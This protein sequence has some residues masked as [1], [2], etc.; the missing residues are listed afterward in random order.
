M[1]LIAILAAAL[2]NIIPS[3]VEMQVKDGC[4]KL[5]PETSFCVSDSQ[6]LGVAEFMSSKLSVSTGFRLPV[7]ECGKGDI[8]LVLDPESGL[9]REGYTLEVTKDRVVATAPD[10]A[11][12]FYAMQSFLQLLP[13]CADSRVKVDLKTWTAPCVSIRDYPRFGWRGFHV[14]P[15]RHFMTVEETKRQIDM[16]SEY[17]VNVMHWHLTDD[18]GWRIEIKKYPR[19]TEVG[20]WRTEF[21]GSVH[22]G[23]YTQEEIR[24]VVAYA[25][26]RFVT[27]VPEIEMPGHSFAAI[28]AYPWLSCLNVPVWD[29][30]V[31]GSP[32]IVLCPGSERVFRFLDDVAAEV[33]A[34]FPGEYF[35][36]G[37][38]ECQKTKWKECDACQARIR[39]EG[40][41]SDEEGT[42]E[43][44]LQSYAVKRMEGI[45]AKYGKKLIG[46]DEILEGGLSPNA[47]VMSWRG[48]K[49][50]IK[51][52]LAGHCVVMTPSHD[53]LYLDHF[54][55]DPKVEPVS[56]G[57]Y[58]TLEKIYGYNPVPEVLVQNGKAEYIMGVQANTWSE[59]LYSI[60]QREYMMY[61]RIFALAEIGWTPLENKDFKDFCRR[62][63]DAC[64]RADYHGINYH[65][66][67]PEQ[68]GGSYDNV[69]FT[70]KA[71]LEFK[72]TRPMRM[73]YTLDGS[74][75]TASSKQYRK[76]LEFTSD[77]TLRIA[78]V[79]TY[80][81]LS[82]VRTITIRKTL[83][84][85]AVT[86]S[87][88]G[89]RARRADGRFITPQD[90]K[91]AVWYEVK[92]GTLRDLSNLEKL[93]KNMPPS[94]R[95]YASKAE[96]YFSVPETGVYVFS[97]DC[98]QV[99]IDG[100]LVIDN[101]G[102]VKRFS[103]HDGG[104]ALEKG[105]HSVEVVFISNVIGGWTS[106]RNKSEVYIRP[107]SSEKS[108]LIS[109]VK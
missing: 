13:P 66:P 31:W 10:A 60:A 55:G 32:D 76:A 37:G 28:R 106:L 75:P 94:V 49:G 51:S 39:Q 59:Y 21:D 90:C 19:L 48:E 46:W 42:A 18:Q 79:T 77:A 8:A 81:K 104:V 15:C 43:E 25:A 1:K 107:V 71:V 27:I 86:P 69:V 7:S 84:A 92:A 38:D 30:G 65:I 47:A 105:C 22:G 64:Q 98:D 80:G 16:L 36:I 56:I 29:F 73:V 40:L 45:L 35:H 5:G 72:T 67:L 53:G 108:Q 61:P 23:F 91:D 99:F 57:N 2:I 74:V 3:P 17:K 93:D 97:S 102:E 88:T 12:L 52:A 33:S 95:F 54:Q 6:A 11:G 78:S 20:G 101:S 14:D 70:D 87:F 9:P 63:D 24:D 100:A 109:I 50:G 62:V 34:L 103:R 44:K 58:T 89:I 41:V 85:K 83:P 4:F 68:V 96:A 82:P 26:E